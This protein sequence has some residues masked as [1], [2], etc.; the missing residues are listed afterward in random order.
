MLGGLAVTA[1]DICMLEDLS[2]HPP[3]RG[4]PSQIVRTPAFARGRW[5]VAIEEI[6]LRHIFRNHDGNGEFQFEQVATAFVDYV[7]VLLDGIQ[8]SW[9]NKKPK[10]T[11]WGCHENPSDPTTNSGMIFT[12]AQ[13]DL[14]DY[15]HSRG[16]MNGKAVLLCDGSTSNLLTPDG[17]PL[18][19]C[20]GPAA[21]EQLRTSLSLAFPGLGHDGVLLKVHKYGWRGRFRKAGQ[22]TCVN[23]LHSG[24]SPN[25]PECLEIRGWCLLCCGLALAFAVR[26]PGMP[27]ERVVVEIDAI[28]PPFLHCSADYVDRSAER[29][30][31]EDSSDHEEEAADGG[32]SS[33]NGEE[34]DEEETDDTR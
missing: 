6:R 22:R 11:C 20:R 8:V 23:H 2:Q 31:D 18:L 1:A 30:R 17:S 29:H 34:G 21:L 16:V 28:V 27:E 32:D 9:R 4:I 12:D 5:G 3:S 13:I 14:L 19:Q 10:I 24:A 33:S 26:L 25:C 15:R 7:R